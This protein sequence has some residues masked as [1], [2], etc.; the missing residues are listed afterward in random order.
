MSAGFSLPLRKA[1]RCGRS[2]ILFLFRL[3]SALFCVLV[4]LSPSRSGL[5]GLRLKTGVEG[6]GERVPAALYSGPLQPRAQLQGASGLGTS[7]GATNRRRPA[8]CLL[9]PPV[10]GT[11]GRVCAPSASAVPAAATAMRSVAF[12][13]AG[14]G[15]RGPDPR[16]TSN[17]N[18]VP[19][20]RAALAGPHTA[21]AAAAAVKRNWGAQTAGC[22]GACK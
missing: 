6:V 15:S 17:L 16:L 22:R 14:L 9:C 11:Q 5:P 12:P 8:L 20:H 7:R 3:P 18:L 19:P 4:S 21:G 2:P 10:P 13:G 1:P